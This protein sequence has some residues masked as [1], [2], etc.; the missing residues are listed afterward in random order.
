MGTRWRKVWR[1]LWSNKTRT[2]LV[3][4]SISVGV[5]AIGM[6]MGAQI[7]V[8]ESLPEAYAAVNPASATI[9]T[10]TT[11][12]EEVVEAID[13]M[14]EVAEAEGR[15]YTA[16]RFLTTDGEW[17]SLQLTGIPD[18]EDVQINKIKAQDGQYPPHERTLSIERA[19]FSPTLGLGD[20][21]VGDTLTIEPPDGKQ[22][23][24]EITGSVHDLSQLPAFMGGSGYGYVSYDTLEWLGE[25]R[26]FN[27][28]VFITAENK[29]DMEHIQEVGSLVR[30]KMEKSGVPVYYVLIFP[31]GEHPALHRS[32]GC[33]GSG[34]RGHRLRDRRRRAR[35]RADF[36]VEALESHDLAGHADVSQLTL[37]GAS[38]HRHADLSVSNRDRWP[39]NPDSRLGQGRHRAVARCG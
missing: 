21:A 14:P 35:P 7:I 11:F 2:V 37:V 38:F 22:R 19:S 39:S 26:D 13:A 27:Q 5:T 29:L 17:R 28:I 23:E 4:L 30:N 9:Y 33:T 12:D 25:P 36:A 6:V 16:M 31:P 32:P 18:F 10:L 3:L 24:I 34:R 1:D 20:V 8:D 15:R